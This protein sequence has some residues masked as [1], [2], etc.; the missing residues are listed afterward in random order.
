MPDPKLEDYARALRVLI[1]AKAYL[2]RRHISGL[3]VAIDQFSGEQ[4]ILNH[5]MLDVAD[6]MI[7]LIKKGERDAGSNA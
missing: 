1:R 7:A 6:A 4:L 2:E 3:V 5:A